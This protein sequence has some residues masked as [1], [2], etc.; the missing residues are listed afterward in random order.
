LR[1]SGGVGVR[2]RADGLI[3]SGVI[4]GDATIC[5]GCGI[6][7]LVCSL[8]HDGVCSPYLSRISLIRD[9]L[10]GAFHQETCRQ[11]DHP[12]C[13]YRCPTRAIYVEPKTGAR[14]INAALCSGCGL[15]AQACPFNGH[16][17][18]IKVNSATNQYIKCDLCASVGTS[19]QCVA[20]CPWGALQYV[21]AAERGI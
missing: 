7:E 18:I 9:P 1:G 5:H 15:C 19:P 13:Y 8:S 21:T 2:G 11:C 3:R 10:A 14:V 17:L 20:A 12:E 6:C 4:V 16:G